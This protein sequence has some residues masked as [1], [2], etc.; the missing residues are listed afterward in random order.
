[1]SDIKLPPHRVLIYASPAFG[2]Q[3]FPYYNERDLIAAVE[4]DR[5]ARAQSAVPE[6]WKLVP[7]EPTPE[8]LNEMRKYYHPEDCME[9]VYQSAI[10][11]AP[12]PKEEP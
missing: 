11:V 10:E 6:G 12:T 5:K 3:K 4:A 7:I 9:L 8:M 1:M 2:Q